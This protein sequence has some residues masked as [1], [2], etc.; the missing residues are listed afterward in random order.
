[1]RT[2]ASSL[3]EFA[4]ILN[5]DQVA[6][7]ILPVVKRC[8]N[9]DDDI[10]ERLFEH[11]DAVLLGMGKDD[12]WDLFKTLADGWRN[13]T[14]GGWRAREKLAAHFPSFLKTFYKT[15][16]LDAVLDIFQLALIDPFAAVRLAATEGVS[17]LPAVFSMLINTGP[18]FI[19]RAGAW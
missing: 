11:I 19:P 9:A 8:L 1:M 14:L 2:T 15:P 16:R 10:R 4:K 12:A 18:C 7:D 6:R 17:R 3:H 13:E 5:P